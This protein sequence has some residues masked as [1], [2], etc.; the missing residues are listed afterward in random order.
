MHYEASTPAEYL[1]AL[2]DDW[3]KEKLMGLRQLILEQSSEIQESIN[4]KMLC[5]SVGEITVL[6]LNAQKNYVSLYAGNI[7]KIDPNGELLEG[8]SLG[9]GCVRLSK[10]KAVSASR[11]DEFI[12]QA[13]KLAQKGIKL[14]C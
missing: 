12:T 5:Y 8:L 2:E 10:S 13:V 4:Y 14:G 9:K 7:E 3:R 6:H 1:G 11:I